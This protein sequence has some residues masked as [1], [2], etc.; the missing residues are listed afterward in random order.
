MP[1]TRRCACCVMSEETMDTAETAFL[2][3]VAD[4]LRTGAGLTPAP[5][6]VD[7]AEPLQSSDLPAVVLSLE[8]V[9]RPG[10]GLGERSEMITDGA[11]PWTA[12]IDLTNPVLPEEPDFVL[13]SPNR[14]ELILP[15]G[16]LRQADGGEGPLGAA[17]LSVTVGGVARTV[18]NT[19]PGADEVR[20]D[21][22]VGL[23]VFGS[24]LPANGTVVAN[25]VLGQ[26][27]RR[28]TQI[29][30][31]LRV[32]VRASTAGVVATLSA[33]VVDALMGAVQVEIKGLR[34]LAVTELS[35][36]GLP[37]T[38]RA[39]SRGRSALFGFDYEHEVNRPD[40]SGGII[41]RVPITSRLTLTQVDGTTG[42]I[43]T[44]L[45]TE[46]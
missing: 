27:E 19:P 37:D 31:V 40:S 9:Q 24:A 6:L 22:T 39:N 26:W 42:A 17:D 25:Y 7:I 44:T 46:V 2:T 3:A 13:L 35:S 1:A 32:D 23:L 21:P 20:A 12:S 4:Y 11:L 36:I 30:G 45:V 34:K 14:R 28:V 5:A 38:L 15:H 43:S 16:G 10:S 29:A 33:A 41:Q 8:T 18:V